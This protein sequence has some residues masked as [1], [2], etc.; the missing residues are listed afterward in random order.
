MP[1]IDRQRKSKSA[2]PI[3]PPIP[4][5]NVIRKSLHFGGGQHNESRSDLHNFDDASLRDSRGRILASS[6]HWRISDRSLQVVIVQCE[7]SFRL[8]RASDHQAQAMKVA[9]IITAGLVILGASSPALAGDL[10]DPS[11]TPGLA[12]P[13]LT[14]DVICSATFSTKAIR[15]VPSARKKAIYKVYGMDP[16][17]PPCP[18]D[19]DHLIPLALGGSNRPRNL[20]PQSETTTPWNSIV[21]DQL[22]S[23]LHDEVCAGAIE[24]EAA[25]HEIATD[26]IAAYI[27]RFGGQR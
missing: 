20:W 14:K 27:A 6:H 5:R 13:A 10:P 23:A 12:D 16:E 21:K 3:P 25:Q 8:L 24:L 9:A 26:W 22:E 1:S 2:L 18:C 4:T 15:N 17:Q 11:I 19:V 7:A